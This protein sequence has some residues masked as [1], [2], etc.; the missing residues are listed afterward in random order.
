M[1]RRLSIVAAGLALLAT[2][3]SPASASPPRPADL[4]V[5]G[6]ADAWHPENRFSLSWTSPAPGSPVLITTR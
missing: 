1:T 2:M 6:G 3:A 4:R 5:V